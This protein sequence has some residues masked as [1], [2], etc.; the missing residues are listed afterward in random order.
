[1]W[2]NILLANIIFILS[3]CATV[4]VPSC[5]DKIIRTKDEVYR[6]NTCEDSD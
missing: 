3:S 5:E 4:T 2:K 6:V 1:M